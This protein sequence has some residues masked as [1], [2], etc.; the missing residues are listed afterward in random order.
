MVH[1]HSV[2]RRGSRCRSTSVDAA[3][4]RTT[5]GSGKVTAAQ[6]GHR[7]PIS[8]GSSDGQVNTSG[9]KATLGHGCLSSGRPR[10]E[11]WARAVTAAGSTGSDRRASRSSPSRR[12]SERASPSSR[13]ST[14]DPP[15]VAVERVLGGEADAG[16]HL[17]GSGG[18][19]CGRRARRGPWRAPRRAADGSSHAA[20][21]AASAASIATRLSASRW[22]TAWNWAIGRPNWMRSSA[23]S[24]ASSSIVRDAPTSSW[25][26][27]R[28]PAAT[29]PAQAAGRQVD[30]GPP[31]GDPVGADLD[32]PEARDRCRRRRRR[33]R[34]AGRA[35]TARRARRRRRGRSRATTTGRTSARPGRRCPGR[36]GDGSR[37]ARPGGS[38]PAPSAGR[39]TPRSAAGSRPAEGGGEHVVEGGRRGARGALQLEQRRHR[40]L[41]VG[42][43]GVAPA[44]LVEG[45][46]ERGARV[47]GGRVRRGS[48][49][50][51][52]A[53]RRPSAVGPQVEQAAGDDVALDLGAA[54][55]DRGRPRVEELGPP[56]ARWRGRRPAA[57]RR[58]GRRPPGRTP[59]ARRWPA[60]SCRPTSRGRAARPPPAGAAWPATGPGRRRA[61][62]TPRPP[63]W[64]STA[65]GGTAARNCSSRR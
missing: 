40:G 32:E 34:S 41:R 18:P 16:Q 22:R 14:S 30:A 54:A 46:V 11:G 12:V 8:C 27:A 38:D 64:R 28:W 61:A 48:W 31:G 65:P 52:R 49:R 17:L 44:Q 6:L 21:S 23:C 20:A 51:A 1:V 9:A 7:P 56:G 33:S 57:R 37:R 59:P 63:R 10:G 2:P 50:T 15:D 55:V 60:G 19:R 43:E 13:S 42:G 62:G 35:T 5:S 4:R 26:R 39:T 25:A 24:R 29:A 53:L 47:L 58:R 45:G 3:P 36:D